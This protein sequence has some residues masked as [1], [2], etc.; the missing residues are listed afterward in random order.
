VSSQ[1][2]CHRAVFDG[3]GEGRGGDGGL[4]FQHVLEERGLAAMEPM[5]VLTDSSAKKASLEKLGWTGSRAKHM[6]LRQAFAK[7]LVKAGVVSLQKVGTSSNSADMLTKPLA[8]APGRKCLALLGCWREV[9][10]TSELSGERA[11]GLCSEGLE[12]STMSGRGVLGGS[13]RAC[14][15]GGSQEP[16][17]REWVADTT[18]PCSEPL[19]DFRAAAIDSCHDVSAPLL[20]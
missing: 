12:P 11:S 18:S 20:A 3:V 2:A 4:F 14:P 13:F 17:C 19:R 7:D 1:P 10:C 6:D 16:H 5:R 15:E 9:A 8:E